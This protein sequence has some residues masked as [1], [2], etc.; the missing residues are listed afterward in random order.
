MYADYCSFKDNNIK[1][2]VSK[3]GVENAKIFYQAEYSHYKDLKWKYALE[4]LDEFVKSNECMTVKQL[5]IKGNEVLLLQGMM[6][7][8]VGD[9][10]NKL[11]FDVIESKVEN[12][13]TAL[14][15]RAKQ[16]IGKN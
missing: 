12:K 6:P 8:D 7:S 16:Y 15:K 3:I 9:I 11:L 2:T 5:D 13:K 10:L 14:I 4:H 1:H